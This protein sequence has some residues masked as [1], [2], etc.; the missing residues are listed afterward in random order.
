ML[1]GLVPSFG[2]AAAPA[3][4]TITTIASTNG[5]G[6]LVIV[7][8]SLMEG[9]VVL[10]S[11]RSRVAARRIWS[12]IVIDY[13]RGRKTPEGTRVLARRLAATKNPTAIVVA[14]GTNDMLSH[15]EKDYPAGII[16]DLMSAS[17]GL[18]VLWVNVNFSNI[19][20]DWR[21]RASRFNRALRAARQDW[22]NLMIAD[23]AR[24][25]V[26]KGRSNYIS[27]GI[28]LSTSGY[29]TRATWMATEIARF[30]TSIIAATTTTT[31]TTTS[32]T[33]TSTT[34]T[35]IPTSTTT[36]SPPTSTTTSTTTSSTTS[37]STTI[38]PP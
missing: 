38:P 25:F 31:T 5:Q 3:N 6:A 18:P 23:W 37:T 11:L 10:G 21:L 7:G 33:S 4:T 24:A 14:L 8:D 17:E 13:R 16:N 19:H 15:S 29:K 27:D 34:S 9:T 30:G 20:P 32:T 26:P 1:C 35:T 28:H 36:T 22:P 2:A 12:R